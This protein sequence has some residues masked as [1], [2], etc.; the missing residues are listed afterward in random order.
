[1]VGTESHA[2]VISLEQPAGLQHC[3]STE[4]NPPCTRAASTAPNDA[5]ALPAD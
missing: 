2:L 1:M 4:A 5:A 3:C